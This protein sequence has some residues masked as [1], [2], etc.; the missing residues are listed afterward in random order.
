[1]K[2]NQKS[3]RG[4]GIL[5]KAS[6][7][8]SFPSFIFLLSLTFLVT[9]SAYAVTIVISYNAG[10]VFADRVPYLKIYYKDKTTGTWTEA[11]NQERHP[12]QNYVK[13]DIPEFGLETVLAA[14][15]PPPTAWGI[16]NVPNPCSGQTAIRY[17]VLTA[18]QITI[19]AGGLTIMD[20]Y[21]EAGNY[22][23][24]FNCA[25]IAPGLY[26][27]RLYSNGG[28]VASFLIQRL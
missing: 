8:F 22:A 6:N 1:M 13:A 16:I 23:R 11:Q 15:P 14:F 21:R 25:G 28:V 24:L 2:R 18:S 10:D 3:Q 4:F 19:K 12:D 17:Q 26:T 5:W 20:E 7:K 9:A 27:L